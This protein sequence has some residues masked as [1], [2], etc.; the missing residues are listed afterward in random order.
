M[1]FEDVLPFEHESDF[2]N[3]SSKTRLDIYMVTPVILTFNERENI[4]RTLSALH[5]ASDVVVLDSGSSDGT[6]EI[7]VSFAT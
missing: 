4:D 3:R 2:P 1:G 6:T 7:A 5:W